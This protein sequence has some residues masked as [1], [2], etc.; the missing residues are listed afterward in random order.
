[1]NIF[2]DRLKKILEDRGTSQA[3]LA[4]KAKTTEAS[5]SRYMKAVH[6]PNGNAV[7]SIA[8]ALNVSADYLLG[9]VDTITPP[10][11]P[12][13]KDYN[14]ES[15]LLVECYHR[16]SD[17]DQRVVWALLDKYMTPEEKGFLDTLATYTESKIG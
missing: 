7:A 4:E 11:G 8:E 1:M 9:I 16:A 3:W 10:G 5:I 15:H 2:A 14:P 17:S 6:F 12:K 13:P